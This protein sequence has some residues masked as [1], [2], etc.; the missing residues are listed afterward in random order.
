M[1]RQA[2]LIDC[3]SIAVA[4]FPQYPLTEAQV[5]A[6][7]ELLGDLDISKA[8][9]YSAIKEVIKTSSFFPSVA[10]IRNELLAKLPTG[11][12]CRAQFV[13]GELEIPNAVAM[14]NWIRPSLGYPDKTTEVQYSQV[15]EDE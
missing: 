8:D 10:D 7:Y 5:I 12:P 6:Y 4:V 1:I 11:I 13:R 9:L 3:L 15:T 2:D 14:P